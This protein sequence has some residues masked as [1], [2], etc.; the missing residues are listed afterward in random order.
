[1]KEK[2]KATR[3][4]VHSNCSFLDSDRGLLFISSCSR[5]HS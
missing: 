1:V 3:T 2:E 4:R 5:L